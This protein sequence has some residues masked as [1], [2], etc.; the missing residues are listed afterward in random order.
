MNREKRKGK[1]R[2]LPVRRFVEKKKKKSE[3]IGNGKNRDHHD[4]PAGTHGP[5]EKKGG[6]RGTG[7]TQCWIC[8]REKKKREKTRT[9][10]PR[11]PRPMVPSS[12]LQKKGR[13][14]KGGGGGGATEKKEKR[15]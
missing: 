10:K 15:D 3:R 14:K 9:Q 7:W 5:G 2:Q 1:K 13:K 4:I 11:Y 12:G 8:D 6:A